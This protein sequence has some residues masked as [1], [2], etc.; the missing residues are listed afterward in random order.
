[1]ASAF[2]AAVVAN[3]TNP[4]TDG[5]HNGKLAPRA[6]EALQSMTTYNFC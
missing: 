1:M 4:C 6:P 5:Y 3:D 2:G